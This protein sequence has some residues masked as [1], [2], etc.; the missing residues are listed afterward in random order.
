MWSTRRKALGGEDGTALPMALVALVILSSLSL[1]FTSLATTEPTIGRNHLMGAQARGFAEGGLERSLWAL[2]NPGH[3]DGIPDPMTSS[4]YGAYDGQAFFGVSPSGGFKLAVSD[5]GIANERSV[6]V[7]GWAPDST[8]QL[9]AARKIVATLMKLQW[10][11]SD[12]PCALC[13]R[14]QLD[15]TGNAQITAFAG[16]SGVTMCSGTVP[17][18]GTMSTGTTTVGGSA[19]IWGPGNAVSNEGVDMPQGAEKVIPGM[20]W[21]DLQ[22]LRSIAQANGTYHKGAVAF[23]NSNRLPAQ[24]G[25]VFVDTT[26]GTDLTNT[27]TQTPESE[28]GSVTITGNQTWSGWLIVLGDIT[29]SGT[30][31]ITGSVY[32]RNDFVFNGNGTITGSVTAENALTTMRSSVDSSASGSSRIVYDCPA[33][34]SGGGTVTTSWLVKPQSY[35][36]VDGQH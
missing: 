14:G 32:A 24:G 29:V 27:P 33:A 17:E 6:S 8:G 34:R 10:A 36:E 3:A 30:V 5:G 7:V 9:R 31:D 23:N 11:Q 13:V 35:R 12:P 4:P 26:T 21:T 16:H 22:V 2:N 25:I 19:D 15:V 18:G 28:M 1:A 20:E